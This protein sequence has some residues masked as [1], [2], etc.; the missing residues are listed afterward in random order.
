MQTNAQSLYPHKTYM[1]YDN[2]LLAQKC[3]ETKTHIFYVPAYRD[4]FL[5][6]VPVKC[7]RQPA[8]GFQETSQG[9]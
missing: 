9:I 6:V 7:C 1:K 5:P 3:V 2:D 8:G 4:Y